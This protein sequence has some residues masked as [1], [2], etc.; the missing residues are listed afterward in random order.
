V[1]IVPHS[2]SL[3]T[4]LT[5]QTPLP[6]HLSPA[7]H[8]VSQPPQCCGSVLKLVQKAFAPLP[9]ES[10]SAEGQAQTPALQPSPAGQATPPLPAQ[11]PQLSGSVSALVHRPLQSSSSARQLVA[12]LPCAQSSPD[13]QALPQLPQ[14]CG[15]VRRLVQRDVAP[16]PQ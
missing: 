10:G 6:L 15:S 13:A 5:A 3:P 9:Q 11:P 14:F 12:Q 7:W 8:A 16:L 2:C 1:Q 4:Q